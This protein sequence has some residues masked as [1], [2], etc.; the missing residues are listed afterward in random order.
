[1]AAQVAGFA[2]GVKELN[3]EL[4]E[5][6][7]ILYEWNEYSTDT[8]EAVSKVQDALESAL[9]VRPSADFI[10]NNL[11]DIQRLAQGD[12]T[13]LDKLRDAA[14]EDFIINLAISD[15]TEGDLLAFI[16]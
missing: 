8:W 2:T 14:T 9:G 4:G 11:E 13:A 15:K 5:N 6:S 10:K 16:N 3:K 1:M 7:S 12:T